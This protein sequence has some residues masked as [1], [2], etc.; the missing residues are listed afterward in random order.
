MAYSGSN[1]ATTF[2][3]ISIKN[4]IKQSDAVLQGQVVS[5]EAEAID[6]VIHTKVT[7]MADKW[8]NFS[9]EEGFVDVY[10]PGGVFGDRVTK[11]FGSPN[12]QVGESVIIFTKIQDQK[13]WINNLG[14]GKFSM[15]RMGDHQVMINQIFPSHPEVGQ[16][17]VDKFV[18]LTEWVKNSKFNKR[19]KNKYEVENDKQ[20]RYLFNKKKRSRSI[21]SLEND[22][23]ETQNKLSDYWLVL[24]L[25]LL[26]LFFGIFRN[27]K[28]E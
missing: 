16:M 15:K 4:Q 24:T 26:G 11:V 7:I 14:L 6:G 22:F 23:S 25:A 13:H 18:D 27:R 2:T 1:L 8:I 3:P 17:R 21:A 10:F 28:N 12:F 5:M 20:V 19:F 9:P